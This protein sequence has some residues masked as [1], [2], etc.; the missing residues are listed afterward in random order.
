MAE[1]PMTYTSE[2]QIT[3]LTDIF[4]R[5]EYQAQALLELMAPRLIF[6]NLW[7]KLKIPDRSVSLKKQTLSAARYSDAGDPRKEIA[8]Q[9]EPGADIAKVTISGGEYESHTLF[10]HA[11]GFDV[12]LDARENIVNI[13]EVARTRKRVGYWLAEQINSKVVSTV[14]NSFSMT[15]TDTAA[16]Y[17][18]FEHI[19]TDFGPETTIGHLVGILDAAYFWDEAGADPVTD[20]MDLKTVFDDQSG[21]PFELDTVYLTNNAANLFAKFVVRNGGKWQQSPLGNGYTTDKVAGV[22]FN[23][24]K[25]DTAGWNVTV[26]DDFIL[27]LDSSNPAAVTYYYQYNELGSVGDMNVDQWYDPRTKEQHYEFVFTR[28]SVVREPNAMTVLKV[29]D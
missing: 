12:G 14:L 19:T 20:I 6:D 5:K 22:T 15:N 21:Y 28:T 25:G 29:R 23:A 7:P 11:L 17:D 10:R 1:K 4:Y 3:L 9:W 27:G 13:D 18:K 8:P 26:G 16:M 24:L 2:S